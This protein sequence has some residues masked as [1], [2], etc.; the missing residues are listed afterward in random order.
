MKVKE[1]IE[2]KI[3][4]TAEKLGSRRAIF[5]V[6][7]ITGN[8]EEDFQHEAGSRVQKEKSCVRQG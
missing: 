3:L 7:V 2:V 1:S 6:Q 8:T 4:N 5:G